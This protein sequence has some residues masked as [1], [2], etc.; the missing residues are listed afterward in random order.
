MLG[1]SS[2][3]QGHRKTTGSFPEASRF[4]Q[5]IHKSKFAIKLSIVCMELLILIN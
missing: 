3:T 2:F 4:K 5:L 1:A